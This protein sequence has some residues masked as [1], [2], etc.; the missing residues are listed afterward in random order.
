MAARLASV[1]TE[2]QTHGCST[3]QIDRAGR[4]ATSIIHFSL[5][6]GFSVDGHSACRIQHAFRIEVVLPAQTLQT[7][8]NLDNGSPFL[9]IVDE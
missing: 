9:D 6:L 1:S 7:P 4:L 3:Q 2:V 5:R 8:T